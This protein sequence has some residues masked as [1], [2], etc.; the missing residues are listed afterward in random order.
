VSLDA[1]EAGWL[2]EVWR[3]LGVFYRAKATVWGA[4]NSSQNVRFLDEFFSPECL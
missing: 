3:L 2:A 4:K 1:S